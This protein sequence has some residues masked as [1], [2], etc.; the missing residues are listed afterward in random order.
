ML[1]IVLPQKR[2]G[3]GGGGGHL[4]LIVFPTL[5]IVGGHVPPPPPP[6][7]RP[8]RDF[9]PWLYITHVYVRGLPKNNTLKYTLIKWSTVEPRYNEV[10]YKKILL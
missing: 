1:K 2:G 3:G 4:I 5:K 7:P 8:L 9:R 6:P 10:G